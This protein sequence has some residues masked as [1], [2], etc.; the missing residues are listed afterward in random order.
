MTYQPKE[1]IL[2]KYADVLVNYA[3]NS[4]SGIKAGEVVFLQVPEC[5]KP[6]L[7]ALRRRIM[8]AG[9]HAIIQFLPD[10]MGRE[11]YELANQNQLEFFPKKYLKG[12]VNQTDHFLALIA[13]TDKH[14]L[15]NVKPQKIMTRTQAFQPYKKWREEKEAQGE[16]SWTMGLYATPAMAKEVGL[17]LSEYW[18][19]IIQA[20]FLDLTDPITKWQEINQK[21]NV[22]REKLNQLNIKKIYLTSENTDLQFRLGKKRRWIGGGGNNIPS[23]EIFTCPDWRSFTGKITFSEPLYAYG[24]LIEGVYLE[25]KKGQVSLAKAKKGQKFLKQLIKVKNADKTGE[26]SLTDGRMSRITHFMGETLYDENRGGKQGNCHIALGS[27]YRNCYTDSINK[28]NKSKRKKLGFND[29]PVH[30]D[31]VSTARR[32]VTAKLTNGTEKVIYKNGRFTV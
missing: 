7:I 13:D 20:C 5:A 26:F 30:V 3:L 16:L 6:L 1:K 28:L 9:A 11:F 10:D 18:Q 8:Q 4:G 12:I 21:I 25:F 14:E 19:Q 27:A 23:F 22:I 2:D 17:S 32:Q 24:N 15:E 29:S 31:F